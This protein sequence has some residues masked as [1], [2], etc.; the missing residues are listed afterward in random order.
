MEQP[1]CRTPG[2]R[3]PWCEGL[4]VANQTRVSG[5]GRKMFLTNPFIDQALAQACVLCSPWPWFYSFGNRGH[6]LAPS[7]SPLRG[8][9]NSGYGLMAAAL[10]N[11]AAR[12]VASWL[13]TV[14]AITVEAGYWRGA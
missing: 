2:E 4:D 3:L 6:K 14:V 9:K 13:S 5:E 7:C 12:K 10:S 1:K 11:S 8:G